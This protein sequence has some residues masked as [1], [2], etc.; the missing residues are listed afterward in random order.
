MLGK[1]W[2]PSVSS[3]KAVELL[4]SSSLGAVVEGA[5]LLEQPNMVPQPKASIAI[6]TKRTIRNI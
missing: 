1:L 3:G 5:S 4:E 6:A 2:F